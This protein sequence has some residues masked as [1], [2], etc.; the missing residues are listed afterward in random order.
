MEP[1]FHLKPR[2]RLQ[3]AALSGKIQKLRSTVYCPE[4]RQASDWSLESGSIRA[5]N[6]GKAVETLDMKAL[7]GIA[8]G[9]FDNTE[10][11][12]SAMERLV[13]ASGGRLELGPGVWA[14]GPIELLSGCTLFLAEGAVLSFIPEPARYRPVLSRWEGIECYAMHPCIFS[15]GQRDVAIEGPGCVDGNGSVWWSL[16]RA[17]QAAG[18]IGPESETEKALALLNLGYEGQPGG[19]GGRATQFLRP[20]AIQFFKCSN[21]KIRGIRVINS[22]FW[23]IHP[24]YCENLEISGVTVTN[25]QDAP[26]TDG[27]DIDSCAGVLIKDCTISVGDDGIALK[28]GS[29]ADGLRVNRPTRDVTV[30]NCTVG[31]GHG[32][33]VI[34]SETAGGIQQVLTEDCRFMGTDRG[35]RIKSRRGRGGDIAD[36]VFRNLVMEGNLCPLTINMYYRCGASADDRRLFSL[37]PEP[38]GSGTPTIRNIRISGIRASGCRASAGFIAGLPESPVE[39]LTIEDSVFSTSE[40]GAVSAEES[41]MYLGIPPVGVKSFRILNAVG[42]R[43]SD[44]QVIGP[45]EPFLYH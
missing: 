9:V 17:K 44:V 45:L 19:G 42:T 28:S 10:L 25:P 43:L 6:G 3:T 35:I 1:P 4:S 5:G 39:N 37:D 8:D 40:N 41:E 11:F 7:G 27:I 18:Q 15:S 2:L 32:G 21:V 22:P 20:P 29:G 12:R 33:I 26:N 13:D 16:F 14:T 24:V 34:G 36:L 31:S 23:S 30:R 38:R